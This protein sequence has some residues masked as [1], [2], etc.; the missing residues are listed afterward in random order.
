MLINHY[1][2]CFFYRS[3]TIEHKVFFDIE[4][5]GGESGRVVMGLFSETPKTSENFRALCT[6]EKGIGKSGKHLHYKGSAFHR[7]SKSLFLLNCTIP[8][9]HQ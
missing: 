3:Q 7:I 9:L 5:K 1:D 6:G 2:L 8:C 4:I